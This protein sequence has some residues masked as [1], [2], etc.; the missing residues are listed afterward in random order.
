[1]ISLILGFRGCKEEKKE[2]NRW[3]RERW[4]ICA[5][6]DG[7]THRSSEGDLR[8]DIPGAQIVLSYGFGAA[9][10]GMTTT[11]RGNAG[12][13]ESINNWEIW[14]RSWIQLELEIG[15]AWGYW[16]VASADADGPTCVLG[17]GQSFDRD[18]KL[19]NQHPHLR[20]KINDLGGRSHA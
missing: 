11:S 1:M 9:E 19:H 17:W 5:S 6:K 2:N 13:E 18:I 4:L 16:L 10:K 12:W 3:E 15:P 8:E 20:R 14:R 7:I